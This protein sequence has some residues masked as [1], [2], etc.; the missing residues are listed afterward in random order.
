MGT[1]M[2]M[3]ESTPSGEAIDLVVPLTAAY[4]S[5]VRIVVASVGADLEFSVDELD[6]LRLGVSEVFNLLADGAVP[7]SRCTSR[8]DLTERHVQIT[9]S[10]DAENTAVELDELASTILRSV[11]DDFEVASDRVILR[12]KA[13]DTLNS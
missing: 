7:N 6:D 12:K 8:F 11:V 3:S 9:M 1:V 2:L 10:R 4:A 13:L 5:T